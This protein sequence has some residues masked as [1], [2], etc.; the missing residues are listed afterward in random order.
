VVQTPAVFL[1]DV[2]A[3]EKEPGDGGGNQ[4]QGEPSGVGKKNSSE[5]Q[6]AQPV[7]YQGTQALKQGQWLGD[8]VNLS[9]VQLI[10]GFRVIIEGQVHT[11]SL[12]VNQAMDFILHLLGLGSPDPGKRAGKKL[13]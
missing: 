2:T 8:G 6:E 5:D 7:L 12:D 9:P 13:A 4:Q 1:Q 10:V 3:H 11:K